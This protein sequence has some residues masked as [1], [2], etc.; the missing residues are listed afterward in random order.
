M[1]NEQPRKRVAFVV[2][3]DADAGDVITCRL[4][5]NTNFSIKPEPAIS[6]GNSMKYWMFSEVSFDREATL[7]QEFIVLCEDAGGNQAKSVVRFDI[8]DKNDEPPQFSQQHYQL[9]VLENMPA[10]TPVRPTKPQRNQEVQAKDR[11]STKLFY[12][13]Q[14]IPLHQS[15]DDDSRSFRIDSNNGR[16]FTT[17]R[18]D[19]EDKEIYHFA[20]LVTDSPTNRHCSNSMN[21]KDGHVTEAKVTVHI[22]DSNDSPPYFTNADEDGVYRFTVVENARRRATVG[23]LQI[24][25]DDDVSKNKIVFKLISSGVEK[26]SCFV[27]VVMASH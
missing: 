27:I 22:Q 15:D 26:V 21:L 23:K 6:N 2:V 8:L 11:D 13:I 5:D 25:D 17:R 19:H 12:C 24:T 16:L 20:V 18:F 9:K 14:P 1:E 3:T 4:T 10:G 7:R